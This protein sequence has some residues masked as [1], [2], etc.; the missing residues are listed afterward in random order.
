MNSNYQQIWH[1]AAEAS[2]NEP[3]FAQVVAVVAG[4]HRVLSP[5]HVPLQ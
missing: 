4:T 2:M 1:I 3:L 5:I